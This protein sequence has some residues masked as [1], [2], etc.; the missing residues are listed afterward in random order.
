MGH[1]KSS[2]Q[3]L[4]PTSLDRAAMPLWPLLHFLGLPIVQG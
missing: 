4:R 2:R 1:S 3:T